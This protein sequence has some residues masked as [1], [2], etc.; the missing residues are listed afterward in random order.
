MKSKLTPGLG[1]HCHQRCND[2]DD[3]HDDDDDGDDDADNKD[4]MEMTMMLEENRRANWHQALAHTGTKDIMMMKI[5][6]WWQLKRYYNDSDDGDYE[7]VME[8]TMMM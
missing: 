5:W 6:W 8:M 2:D 7:D 1:S 4:V 3:Y